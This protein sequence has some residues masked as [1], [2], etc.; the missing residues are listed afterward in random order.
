MHRARR[1]GAAALARDLGRPL[2]PALAAWL[3]AAP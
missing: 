2:A 1:R 3:A